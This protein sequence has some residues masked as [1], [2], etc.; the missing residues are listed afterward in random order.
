MEICLSWFLDGNLF[1]LIPELKFVEADSSME[2][3]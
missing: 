3:C 1:K 2:I